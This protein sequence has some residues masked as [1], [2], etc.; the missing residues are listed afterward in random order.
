MLLPRKTGN[1]YR[2]SFSV[3]GETHLVLETVGFG[4]HGAGR[5]LSATQE[6][7]QWRKKKDDSYFSGRGSMN[8][9]SFL[10]M[11][12]PKPRRKFLVI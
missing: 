8:G 9:I 7:R 3:H 6:Q 5:F 12:D 1:Q 2:E 10:S 11:K 4:A